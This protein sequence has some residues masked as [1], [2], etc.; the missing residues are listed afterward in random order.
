MTLTGSTVAALLVLPTLSTPSGADPA[1]GIIDGVVSHCPPSSSYKGR[2]SVVLHYASGAVAM[3]MT[4]VPKSR[5]EHFAFYTPP[6]SY[7][8]IVTT[9]GSL[10]WPYHVRYFRVSSGKTVQLPNF[11]NVCSKTI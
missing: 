10:R 6:G 4:S 7:N 1:P 2:V 8:V 3:S 5:P 9:N 11:V